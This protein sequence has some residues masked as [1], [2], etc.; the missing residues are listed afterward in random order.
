V[1]PN[2]PHGLQAGGQA[3]A[4]PQGRVGMLS[5]AAPAP[6]YAGPEGGLDELDTGSHLHHIGLRGKRARANGRAV[7]HVPGL[8]GPRQESDPG[9]GAALTKCALC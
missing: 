5:P 1:E 7:R 2:D 6:G 4:A 9:W 3:H 8:Y